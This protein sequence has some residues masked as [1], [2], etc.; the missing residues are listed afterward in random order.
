MHART[1]RNDVGVQLIR[2]RVSPS[3]AR[4]AVAL[5]CLVA[6]GAPIADAAPA[7]GNCAALLKRKFPH[8]EIVASDEVDSGS[9]IAPD[10]TRHDVPRFCRIQGEASPSRDSQIRFELWMPTSGWNGRYYQLGNGGYAG[11]LP[12]A[13]MAAELHRGNA[14]AATDTGHRGDA[15]D[16][17]WARGRPEKIVDYGWRS[18]KE[19]SDAAQAL[20]RAYYGAAASRRYFAGCSNGGRQ[21]LLLAQRFPDDWDGILAGAPAVDWTRQLASFAWIQHTLRSDSENWI[22]PA[23][24]SVIQRAA[25]E[26]CTS[27]A[28]VIDGVPTDPRA[29]RFDPAAL[30]CDGEETDRCLTR[31][32]AE[33]LAL[34]QNGPRDP[35]TGAHLYFGFEPTAAAAKA[36]WDQ[37]IVNTDRHASSQLVLGEQF[38][39]NM[40]FADADWQLE[41]FDGLRDF[42]LAQ[43]TQVAGRPIDSLLNATSD[44]LSR[45][46]Q[47]GA[48][49]LMYFGWHDALISPRAGVAYYEKV[50]E[51]MDGVTNTQAFFRLFM[52]PGMTHCQGG[53]GPHAFG[54]SALTPGLRDDAAH[55]IRRALEAWVE[56]GIAP[57]RIIAAR[58]VQDDPAQGVAK[59]GRL[60]P[61]PETDDCRTRAEGES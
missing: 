10:D 54:Q 25:I 41:K 52:V 59:I 18:L 5:I 55:D 23:K 14:V 9:Y 6:L 19:T 8:F 34:I 30:I 13:L 1:N 50:L 35:A 53:P 49:L 11:T 57:Q 56:R 26:S 60:C 36:N 31:K 37:W 51:R 42:A 45:F 20:I 33:S 32:Q 43:R 3:A 39:R 17:T 2:E 24:L 46:K 7:D 4:F 21:A 16:A 22:E 28:R 29:C 27:A 61:F 48:K 40:V 58:Y 38:F 12:Y 44:D 47:R 15:F